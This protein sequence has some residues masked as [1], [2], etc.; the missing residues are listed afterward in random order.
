MPS[1]PGIS[2]K[3]LIASDDRDFAELLAF[4]V[5][6]AGFAATPATDLPTTL[7]YARH[8]QLDIALVDLDLRCCD[9]F[10]LLSE[11]R[12]ISRIPILT[13]SN[14]S[15]E[16]DKVRAFELGTD[17]YLTRPFGHRELLVRVQALTRRGFQLLGPPQRHESEIRIGPLTLNAPE[18]LVTLH[19]RAVSLT[20]TEFRMLEYLMLNAGHVVSTRT[21]AREVWGWHSPQASNLQRVVTH[22]LRSKLEDDP[23]QPRMLRTVPGIGVIL[24]IGR[25]KSTAS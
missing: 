2:F 3:I 20:A 6:R 14:R 16:D 11:L 7:N 17:D 9:G 8:A 25:A 15:S 1:D 22:R 19:G 13:V 18:H 12:R 23:H 4:V 24:D 21:L 10:I 5:G